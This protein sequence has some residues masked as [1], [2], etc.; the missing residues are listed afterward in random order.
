MRI[1]GQRSA[2]RCWWLSMGERADGNVGVDA[3][4]NTGFDVVLPPEPCIHC[5]QIR[6]SAGCCGDAL[7]QRLQMLDIRRLIAV[8]YRHDH[9]MVAV[10][11]HQSVAALQQGA[12]G[13]HQV[14]VWI[15]V[16]AAF[17]AA[18]IAL[19]LGGRCAVSF[20]GQSPAWHCIGSK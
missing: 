4:I 17:R 18:V 11:R 16:G 15:R 8:A 19:G 2:F 20:A 13:L 7:Q 12:A 10:D 5:H 1:L 6:Q 9:L 3:L 14:A